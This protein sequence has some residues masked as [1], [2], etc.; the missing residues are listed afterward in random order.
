LKG[1]AVPHLVRG[2]LAALALLVADP[3]PALAQR[4]LVSALRGGGY[5]IV[6]RH[7][8]APADRPAA[9]Q[10]DP[11]NK[12][13]ERQLDAAG[14]TQARAVGQAL[15]AERIP[16]GPV[17]SSPTFRALQTARLMGFAKPE[18][19]DELGDGG[20]SMAAGAAGRT[21]TA[22]LKAKAGQAPPPGK[23][24]LVI[25]HGP[26]IVLAFGD[27]FKDMADAEAA[28]FRPDGKGGFSLAGRISTDGWKRQ[29]RSPGG[30]APNG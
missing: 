19:H 24:A 6:M 8:H 9:G 1:T 18:A 20:S 5:V 17:Y 12:A 27:R 25:T 28:V 4:D 22:W 26:N 2:L 30:G 10:A 29:A 14:E 13:G 21:G 16:I 7:A 15:K 23:D 11:G 3:G